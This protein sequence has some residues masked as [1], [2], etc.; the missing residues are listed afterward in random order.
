MF[1]MQ[2]DGGDGRPPTA[3]RAAGPACRARLSPGPRPGPGPPRPRA[4]CPALSA[5]GG[6]RGEGI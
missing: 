1:P 4:P 6:E 3:A 2:Q 5:G